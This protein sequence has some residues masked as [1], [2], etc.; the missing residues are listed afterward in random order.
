MRTNP[1]TFIV[2]FRGFQPIK[3]GLEAQGFTVYENLWT[4]TDEQLVAIAVA[5]H[6]TRQRALA[7]ISS[8]SLASKLTAGTPES[9]HAES[10]IRVLTCRRHTRAAWKQ[11]Q[12]SSPVAAPHFSNVI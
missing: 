7:L 11:L 6:E 3:D 10:R 12:L 4:P 2:N 8:A 5:A 9:R 1:K